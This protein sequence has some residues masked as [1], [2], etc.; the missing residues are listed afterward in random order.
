MKISSG[1]RQQ[2]RMFTSGLNRLAAAMRIG[3]SHRLSCGHA[4]A[5][6]SR[7]EEGGALIEIA[8]TVPVL[9]GILTGIVT[10]GFA[11][12]N[13]L[14]LTQATGAA[15]QYLAQ[16]RTSTTDPCADAFTA[17]KNAAPGLKS[18]N[19]NM[20]VTLNGTT[21]TQTNESCSGKQTLLVQG[22]PVSVYATYPCGLSVYGVNLA[23]SCQFA[24]KVTEYEY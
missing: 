24:A 8:L 7:G 18:S 23:S 3:G 13:Q 17:L 21:P 11:Y 14:T 4:H 6:F 16:I 19:I 5:L 22:T 15:G 10:F 2:A 12:S 9:L 1:L 20:I